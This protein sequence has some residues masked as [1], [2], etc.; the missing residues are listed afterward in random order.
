[1][2]TTYTQA[3]R[4]LAA[5]S[6]LGPDQLLLT[7]FSGEEALSKLFTYELTMVSP[8]LNI[9]ARDIVGKGVTWLVRTKDG[10]PRYFHGVVARWHA[11]SMHQRDLR[12]YRAEVVP[13]LWFLTCTADCRIFQHKSTPEIV[14]MIFQEMGFTDY[15][16][17]LRSS[18]VRREYCVQYRETDFNFISHLLERDGIWYYFRHEEGKHT[19]V[20]ADQKGAYEECLENEVEFGPGTKHAGLLSTWEHHYEFRPGKWAGTDYNF[21]IP[22]TDLVAHA[23]T[24]VE[25]PGNSKYEVFDYPGGYANIEAGRARAKVR[26]E[27]IEAGFDVA[28][29][30]STCVTFSP[31]YSFTVVKH[32]CEAEAGQS[33]VVTSI[34]HSAKD[35]SYFGTG[36]PGEEYKNTFTCIPDTVNFRPPRV[37]RR[38]T[39]QGTQTAV[40]VGPKGEEIFTD[41]HGRVKV[42]FHWDREGR[43]RRN[44]STSCWVRVSQAWAGKGWG[45]FIVPRIGQEVVVDFLEGNPDRPLIISSIYNADQVP[46]Y[47]KSGGRDPEHKHDPALMS[48]KTCS[49]PG[50]DGFNELRFNDGKGK[51]QLFMHAQ[52]DMDVRVKNDHREHIQGSKHLIIGSAPNGTGSGSGGGEGTTVEANWHISVE[53][54]KSEV[55]EKDSAMQAGNVFIKAAGGSGTN[56]DMTLLAR[57][58]KFEDV[59]DNSQVRVGNDYRFRVGGNRIENVEGALYTRVTHTACLGSK[60]GVVIIGNKQVSI[61]SHQGDVLVAG[62]RVFLGN[63]E[64]YICMDGEAVH[65]HGK[66]V[67]INCANAPAWPAII[68]YFKESP[69]KIGE[70]PPGKLIAP[71]LADN[72]QTG[73]PSAS[74]AAPGN[75]L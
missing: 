41:D 26:I 39:V 1:M 23:D 19:L 66:N 14:E 6:P 68:K 24:V 51:E 31:G 5:S 72:G 56:G 40:V 61:G 30:A 43:P 27:E 29:G 15:E 45:T 44:E 46:H 4:R 8:L 35:T 67:K 60:E 32:E 11:G 63:N 59:G 9:P 71:M 65:I 28:S 22:K 52:R 10:Q 69:V 54:Y 37:T 17:N 33:F 73:S 13:W 38:P 58:K 47:L 70:P 21:E 20:L 36:Q 55:I 57:M 74:P 53:G 42:H 75:V 12:Y 2:A 3:G 50:G 64:N 62:G 18:Y 34:K 25:L 49:T 48:I 7:G 16:L